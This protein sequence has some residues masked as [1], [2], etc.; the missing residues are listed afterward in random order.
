[1]S[2]I[3]G[4]RSGLLLSVGMLVAGAALAQGG[5][6]GYPTKPVRVV[7]P[8]AAGSLTDPVG[9]IVTEE[10][11]RRTGQAWVIDNRPGAG[12]MI[13]SENVARSAADGYSLLFTANNF[14]ITP[15]LYPTT[16][17]YK[18]TEDF[19]PIGLVGRADNLLVASAAAGV[20]NIQELV[21]AARRAPSG[22]DYTS[23]LLGSA[24]HLTVE[25]FR[26]SAGIK[27]NHIAYKDATQ[28]TSDTLSGRIPVNIMGISTALPHI[29]AGKLVPLAWTGPKRA[30]QL[31]DTPTFVE[32]GFKDVHLGLWFGYFGPAKMPAAQVGWLNQQIAAALKHPATV[33]KLAGIG[34]EPIIASADALGEM[35]A[36]EQPVY[37]K[38]VAD[39]GLKLE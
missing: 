10:L 24:A 35:V 7:I 36:R 33:E 38:V 26:S 4:L 32:A 6:G 28:G 20:K 15:S 1:M 34:I 39:A 21:A 13:G 2:T 3:S 37:A 5:P 29:R 27:L 31:P 14:I 12:G 23:P 17:R 25:L 11:A 8:A 18:V 9:R 30:S 19:T 16:I 22:L